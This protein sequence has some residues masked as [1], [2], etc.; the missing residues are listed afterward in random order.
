MKVP[1][2]LY[3]RQELDIISL[4]NRGYVVVTHYG[5]NLH[6]PLSDVIIPRKINKN[7]IISI[8]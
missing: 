3:P 4:F 1:A 6:S 2:V 7:S 5:F 8:I